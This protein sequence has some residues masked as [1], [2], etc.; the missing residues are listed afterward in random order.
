MSC[1]IKVLILQIDLPRTELLVVMSMM[2]TDALLEFLIILVKA[3]QVIGNL[4]ASA[5]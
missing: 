4:L 1:C 5:W 2:Q 3:S